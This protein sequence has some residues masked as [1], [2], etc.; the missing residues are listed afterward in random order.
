MCKAIRHS[1]NGYRHCHKEPELL[2][3]EEVKRLCI[4]TREQFEEHRK[5]EGNSMNW[6]DFK[7]DPER[8][9]SS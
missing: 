6:T 2:R 4:H 8:I 9:S 7:S 3:N 1:G 5:T